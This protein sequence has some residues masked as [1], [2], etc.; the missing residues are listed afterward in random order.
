MAK[1]AVRRIQQPKAITYSRV[2]AYGE[3][4][5][6]KVNKGAKNISMMTPNRKKRL[7]AT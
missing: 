3:S 6:N 4:N 5:A 7:L 1:G 2:L